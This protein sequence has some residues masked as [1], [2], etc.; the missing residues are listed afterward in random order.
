MKSS[1]PQRL[2]TDKFA[3]ASEVW[4]NFIENSILCYKPGENVTIYAQLFP[5]KARYRFTQYIANK[6]DKFGIK[7]WLLADVDS[8]YLLNGFPYLGKDEH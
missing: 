6:H 8:K 2:Q 3:L 7:F 4:K 1:R 5:T